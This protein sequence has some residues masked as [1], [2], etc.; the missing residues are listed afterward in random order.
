MYKSL[1]RDRSPTIGPNDL[2]QSLKEGYDDFNA[3][4]LLAC[5]DWTLIRC[6]PA[7]D[8]LLI[9][10]TCS[11]WPFQCRGLHFIGPWS[12]SLFSR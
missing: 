12:R 1:E 9:A 3:M 10:R 7:P 6:S 4:Q 2:W 8:T 5:S 11:I